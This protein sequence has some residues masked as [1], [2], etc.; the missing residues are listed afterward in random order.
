MSRAWARMPLRIKLTLAFTGV[1]AVLLAVAGIALSVLVARNLDGAI[2]AGLEAR[3]GDAG[4]LVA[5]AVQSGRLESSGEPLAQV[6]DPNGRVLDTTA[7]AGPAP[8]LNGDELRVAMA[9]PLKIDRRHGAERASV[10][11]Y[12]RR[13]RTTRGAVVVVV[14][15]PLAQREQSLDSL[16]ALL[17]VGGPLA[18]LVA[19]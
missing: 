16:R 6:L 1:M 2:D 15:E 19:S 14:G 9:G 17:A 18:L 11:L 5:D 10:R 4:A 12:A 7:G 8:L 3:A 13:A